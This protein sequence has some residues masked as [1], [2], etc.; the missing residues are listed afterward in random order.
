MKHYKPTSPSRRHMTGIEFRKVITASEPLKSLTFGRKRH[1]GRNNYGRLTTRHKGGGHKRLFREVDFTY[2]KFDILAK[3]IS[4]SRSQA[5]LL[6]ILRL[7][8]PVTSF[9]MQ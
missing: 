5:V 2:D 3:I 4:I 1:V 8:E 9:N 6:L 7:L